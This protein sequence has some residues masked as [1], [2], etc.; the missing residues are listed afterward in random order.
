MVDIHK[1]DLAYNINPLL[2]ES[3]K[4]EELIKQLLHVEKQVS[5]DT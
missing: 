4:Y 1:Q 5:N 3:T 2:M